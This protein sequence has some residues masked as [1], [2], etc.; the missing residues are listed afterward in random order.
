ML[1]TPKELES[2]KDL[3][4]NPKNF[5]EC[6]ICKKLIKIGIEYAIKMKLKDENK[7]LYPHIHLHGNPLHGMVCYL[8]SHFKVRS[9]SSIESIEISR[10]SDTLNQ[11]MKKW[12]NPS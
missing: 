9:I 7:V 6:P 5:Y 8:D 3:K 4:Q 1:I 11:V 12:S 2:I 10:D